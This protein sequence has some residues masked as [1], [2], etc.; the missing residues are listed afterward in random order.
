MSRYT[1]QPFPKL[2]TDIPTASLLL[3]NAPHPHAATTAA[4]KCRAIFPN[5]TLSVRK[6]DNR[7]AEL[8][9]FF[10]KRT[11]GMRGKE[12]GEEPQK[13]WLFRSV[14]NELD[15]LR[16]TIPQADSDQSKVRLTGSGCFPRGF[17]QKPGWCC[18]LR[19]ILPTAGIRMPP[20]ILRARKEI[21]PSVT[22]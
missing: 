12:P 22:W 5:R 16:R 11:I 19:G 17:S 1:E 8:L 2:T 6:S 14:V 20:E 15:F 13:A 7:S 3:K 4:G 9:P 10:V 18:L 21:S